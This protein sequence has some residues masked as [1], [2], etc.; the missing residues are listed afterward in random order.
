MLRCPKNQAHRINRSIAIKDGLKRKTD[1]GRQAFH[2]RHGISQ[3]GESLAVQQLAVF[4]A[5]SAGAVASNI[6]CQLLLSD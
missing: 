6:A 1:V 5:S 4:G 2:H 3:R